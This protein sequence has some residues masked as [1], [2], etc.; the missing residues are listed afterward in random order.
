MPESGKMAASAEV[1]EVDTI[2][3]K[4]RNRKGKVEYLV[5][6]K[7]YGNEDN[8]WEPVQNLR[9]CMQFIV[10]YNKNKKKNSTK[11]AHFKKSKI[12]QLVRNKKKIITKP[13][14]KIASVKQK[15]IIKKTSKRK[16]S[17]N[18]V[19]QPKAKK[20]RTDSPELESDSE[21]SSLDFPSDDDDDIRYQLADHIIKSLSDGDSVA[22]AVNST[23]AKTNNDKKTVNKPRVHSTGSKANACMTA[24]NSKPTNDKVKTRTQKED[25]ACDTAKLNSS[26]NKL[27]DD[28]DNQC[29]C[30]IKGPSI[31]T[32]LSKQKAEK[33]AEGLH[34]PSKLVNQATSPIV[35]YKTL[36]GS[37]PRKHLPER[38]VK[39]ALSEMNDE[40]PGDR[41][42]SVRQS[43]SVF[44]Y[45]EIVVKKAPGYTQIW[46]FTNT[47]SKN[48]IN[49]QVCKE[50]INALYNATYDDSKVVMLSG[51]GSVFCSGVDLNYLTSKA[52]DGRRKTALEMAQAL[53]DLVD[54]VIK[55]PKLL[56][57]AVNGP[58]VGLGVALLPLCDIVYAS[59]KAC[60]HTPYARL[61]QTP[62]GGASYTFPLIMG[63]AMANEMLLAGRKLTALEACQKGL[64]SQVFWPTS[65]MQEVIPRL[66]NMAATSG[67]GLQIS[68]ALIR[69]HF[70]SKVEYTNESECIALQERWGSAEGYRAIQKFVE[71]EKD[72]LC[73]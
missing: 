25:T 37:T 18:S 45:K 24:V 22:S 27:I 20:Q 30:K 70:K 52:A 14:K 60:F 41:R 71:E 59:D 34:A 40:E 35:S 31:L 11:T 10:A 50:L 63:P 16:P 6:W 23:A 58:A 46:L 65:F 56:V 66:Q 47:S 69:S 51:S 17:A 55:F 33:P 2:L 32:P 62:E 49:P 8:T 54:A 57:A 29:C 26:A 5:R 42:H 9:E 1:Y 21:H 7:N 19:S 28:A 43:E 13:N 67:K 64:V 72:D 68:K 73:V 4:R 53:R 3:A 44:K 36:L 15:A 61:A 39:R 48:A 38:A 12:N